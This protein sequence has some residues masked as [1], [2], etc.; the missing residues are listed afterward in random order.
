MPVTF[1]IEQ[2]EEKSF[3]PT[4]ERYREMGVRQQVPESSWNRD[5]SFE[6]NRWNEMGNMRRPTSPVR[7]QP[8]PIRHRMSP[9]KGLSPKRPLLSPPRRPC[10]PPRR[11]FSPIYRQ[12]SPLR[13]QM[14]PP[15]RPVPSPRRIS[16]TRRPLSPRH[17]ITSPRRNEVPMNRPM[18]PLRHQMSPPRRQMS[19]MRPTMSP[20]RRQLSPIRRQMSP[21]RRQIPSPNRMVASN[22]QEMLMS[23]RQVIIPQERQQMSPVKRG[24]SPQFILFERPGSPSGREMSPPQGFG[25]EW[26]IPSRRAVEQN[27]WART[28]DRMPEQNIWRNN[29]PSTSDN[30]WD[31][32]SCDDGQRKPFNQEKWNNKDSGRN[33]TWSSGGNTWSAKQVSAKPLMPKETWPSNSDNRWSNTCNMPGSSNNDNWNIRGKD[34]FPARNESWVDNKKQSRWESLNVKETWKQNDKDDVNDLP[35][36]ARDRSLGG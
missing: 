11:H 18:S 22:R 1:P 28:I 35:E 27:T 19:P 33:E 7:R 25:D 30:N 4:L 29:K 20:P 12:R 23:R 5:K 13:R 36:D 17:M 9:P 14:S 15:R 2:R 34:S 10:S 32:S 24:G 21:P 26:D 31:Q 3:R 6:R 8:S 16:P